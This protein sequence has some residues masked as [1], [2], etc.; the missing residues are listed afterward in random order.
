MRRRRRAAAVQ[1]GRR[2]AGGS[3]SAMGR[4]RGARRSAIRT[5]AGPTA[6]S[7]RLR[8]AWLP[9]SCTSGSCPATASASG[10]RTATNGSSPSSRARRP[11]L[12]L[13]TINPAY[14]TS[15]LEYAL[16]KVG[17][18]AL[19]LAPSFKTSDYAAM[20]EQ[21][22]AEGADCCAHAILT[23]DAPRAGFLRYRGRR[24][25][26]HRRGSRARARSCARSCSPRTRSTSSSRAARPA[27]RRARRCLITTSS[28]T[29]TSSRSA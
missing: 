8:T 10:R 27:C 1:D 20:L 19:V 9:A 29:A 14:R 3:G 18:K 5:S 13:V 6:S 15:E 12:I 11:G 22:R 4:A 17:C 7:T 28:T 26:R 2:R 16:N 24:V 23:D 21:I 25:V